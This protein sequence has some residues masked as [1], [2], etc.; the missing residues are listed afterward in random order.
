MFSSRD[1][2]FFCVF[3]FGGRRFTKQPFDGGSRQLRFEYLIY[4]FMFRFQKLVPVIT[5]ETI[6]MFP[7]DKN[8]LGDGDRLVLQ[9]VPVGG[10]PAAPAVRPARA[11]RLY[12]VDIV[13][14]VE[15]L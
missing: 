1:L 10:E 3:L 8:I 11:L 7:V 12:P 15:A 4:F 2:A 6:R 5:Y 14:E 13:H 9:R